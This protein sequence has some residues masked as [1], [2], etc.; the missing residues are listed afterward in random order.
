MKKLA[1]A[2]TLSLLQ[3]SNSFAG[4]F[5]YSCKVS[6]L[7]GKT[8]G[9]SHLLHVDEGKNLVTFQGKKYHITRYTGEDNNFVDGPGDDQGCAK[10]C[11][12]VKGSDGISFTVGTATKGLAYF[13]LMD[14]DWECE[15]GRLPQHP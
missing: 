15:Q 14:V 11:W 8:Y 12:E 5:N 1:I 3:V 9:K 13:V 7:P 4:T 2:L 6:I 10:Y